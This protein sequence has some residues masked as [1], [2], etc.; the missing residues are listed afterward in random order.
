MFGSMQ[1]AGLLAGWLV[2]ERRWCLESALTHSW[3]LQKFKEKD[4]ETLQQII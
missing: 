2:E 3:K 1:V 4:L